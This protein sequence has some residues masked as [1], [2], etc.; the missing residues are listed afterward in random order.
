VG[1]DWPDA[2]SSRFNQPDGFITAPTDG[3][4]AQA[5]HIGHSEFANCP[6]CG[7]RLLRDDTWCIGCN[8]STV[9]GTYYN[10]QYD[11][12]PA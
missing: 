11:T 4:F 6:K 10:V 5:T 2:M 7:Y 3:L 8:W 12:G 9:L 1:D